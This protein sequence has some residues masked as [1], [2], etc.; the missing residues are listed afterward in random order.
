MSDS[1]PPKLAEFLENLAMFPDRS[2]RIEALISVAE[3]F[4]PVQPDVAERPFDEQNRVQGCESEVFVWV[5]K[6]ANGK[7]K[8]SFAVE[9][10]QGISARALAVIL[11]DALNGEDISQ[12]EKVPEDVVY[13]IFGRELSMGKSLGLTNPVRMVKTLAKRI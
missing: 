1:L 9:N 12:I 7:A 6:D 10:P 11:G 8:V 2:D 4:V 3:R 13:T 5:G